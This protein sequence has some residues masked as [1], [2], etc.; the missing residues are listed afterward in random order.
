MVRVGAQYE[1]SI[2]ALIVGYL[3]F[4]NGRVL[5]FSGFKKTPEAFVSYQAFVT[6]FT[7]YIFASDEDEHDSRDYQCKCP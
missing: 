2:I 1:E 4:I 7:C 3:L 5:S 6:A